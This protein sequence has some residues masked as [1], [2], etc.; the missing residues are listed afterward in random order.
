MIWMILF[1]FA[2]FWILVNFHQSNKHKFS[3]FFSRVFV[4]NTF[5]CVLCAL[6]T[7]ISWFLIDFD[8]HLLSN[9]IIPFS[10]PPFLCGLLSKT[11]IQNCK[12][13]ADCMMEH[14]K[15]KIPLANFFCKLCIYSFAA[16]VAVVALTWSFW[17]R[18]ASIYRTLNSSPLQTNRLPHCIT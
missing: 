11:S 10:S 1:T 6:L 14:L 9:L 18:S 7:N 8:K 2:H 13:W 4:K 15:Q 12:L 16:S 3:R 17:Q 5:L